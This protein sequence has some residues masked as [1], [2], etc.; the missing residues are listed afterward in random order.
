MKKVF[1][2][3]TLLLFATA[4]MSCAANK[5]KLQESDAKLL[6]QQDLIEI[7][8]EKRIASFTFQ[9][10]NAIIKPHISFA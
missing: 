7:F 4:L 9:S 5:K 8:S 3:I 2:V 6:S 10:G 1:I